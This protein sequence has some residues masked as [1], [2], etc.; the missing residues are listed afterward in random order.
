MKNMFIILLKIIALT[1]VAQNL[2]KTND[3]LNA[4]LDSLTQ[5]Y[6]KAN[7]NGVVLIAKPDGILYRGAFGFANIEKKI[8]M[9]PDKFFKTESVG[10]MFTSTR[11]LQLVTQGKVSLNKTISEYLPDWKIKNGE[12]ITIHQLLNHT[13]GLMSPWDDPNYDFKRIYS[14]GELKQLLEKQGVAFEEP[15]TRFY[16]SNWGYFLLGEVISKLDGMPY[17]EAIQQRIFNVAGMKRIHHLNDTIMPTN[18][19]QP[20]YSLSS[21]HA[22]PYNF[23]LGP[24]ATP[25]GGW[26]TDANDLLKFLQTYLGNKFFDQQT[27]QLQQTANHTL[28]ASSQGFHYAYGMQ[29]INDNNICSKKIIGHNGGGAG[30]SIDVFFEPESQYIVVMCSNMYGTGFSITGNYFNL[31]WGKPLR[32]VQQGTLLRV[33]DKIQQEGSKKLMDHPKTFFEEIG[34]EPSPPLLINASENLQQLNDLSNASDV[35]AVARELFPENPYV[36]LS[37]GGVERKKKDP[38]LAKKHYEKALAIG[39]KEKNDHVIETANANLSE[40]AKFQNK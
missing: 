32:K 25:A 1:S 34:A 20:Y 22:I 33:V 12:K 19:A 17:D 5:E 16:Y 7:F 24:K 36:W 31:L 14:T 23:T 3:A 37:S 18:E 38:T 28:D 27:Q 13:S 26:I 29:V 40:L 21:S 4:R 10:K 2:S 30:F 9:T 35:L 39:T 11:I 6:Q 8:P 15:G